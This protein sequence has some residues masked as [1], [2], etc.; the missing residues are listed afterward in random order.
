M[1]GPSANR[2]R[3]Q[4]SGICRALLLCTVSYRGRGDGHRSRIHSEGFDS[5]GASRHVQR[6]C[7]RGPLS[8]AT[9][10]HVKKA[11]G[12]YDKTV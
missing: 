6:Y 4:R 2:G 5:D 12:L 7:G 9:E 11:G 8:R 10:T 3:P 1:V